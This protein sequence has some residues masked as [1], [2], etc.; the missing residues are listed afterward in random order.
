MAFTQDQ[1]VTV[2]PLRVLGIVIHEVEIE[3]RHHFGGRKGTAG[4]PRSRSSGHFD[5]VATD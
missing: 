5:D 1:T 2:R 3:G 4:M